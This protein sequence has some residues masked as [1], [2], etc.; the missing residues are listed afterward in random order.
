MADVLVVTDVRFYR[1]GL[2]DV[3]SRRP[4]L[5]V[6]GTAADV[7]G[8]FPLLA[9]GDATIVLLDAGLPDAV[10]AARRIARDAPQVM[11]VALALRET[12]QDVI[13][14]AEAGLACYVSRDHSIG[15]L[16]GVIE[17]VARSELVCPPRIAATLLRRVRVLASWG[18]HERAE[19]PAV[20]L[21]FREREIATLIEAGLS[22]KEIAY[23]LGIQL[24]TI[25]TH[26]H[27]ILEKLHVRRRI[28]IPASV[29]RM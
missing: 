12:D 13:A 9:A 3:L 26:V 11:V 15:D 22:N 20:P 19:P 6:A 5:R 23:R 14:W 18:G 7:E 29:R 21:T 4:G 8:L 17:S 16:V 27:H 10:D 24:A 1:E 28:Q 25:K 2:V